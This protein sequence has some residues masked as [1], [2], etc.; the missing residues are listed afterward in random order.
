MPLVLNLKLIYPLLEYYNTKN[1]N[2][3]RKRAK[4]WTMP[5]NESRAT[6]RRLPRIVSV[7][8]KL[9]GRWGRRRRRRTRSEGTIY[10]CWRRVVFRFRWCADCTLSADVVVADFK[11][12]FVVVF[13]VLS[14]SRV[15]VNNDNQWLLKAA[16]YVVHN[17]E[18]GLSGHRFVS[19]S[20]HSLSL[21]VW[22]REFSF[23]HTKLVNSSGFMAKACALARIST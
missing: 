11:W 23:T 12:I 2:R 9:R 14:T 10:N 19:P 21:S 13:A 6:F 4:G 16:I 22:Q 5:S 3:N 7:A 1:D 20:P 8:C 18:W 15:N 17:S